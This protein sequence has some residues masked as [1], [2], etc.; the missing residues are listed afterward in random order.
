MQCVADSHEDKDKH[1]L[2]DCCEHIVTT[3]AEGLEHQLHHQAYQRN[4]QPRD[5]TEELVA[6]TTINVDEYN[7]VGQ[8]Q[9]LGQSNHLVPV[10]GVVV[11]APKGPNRM[12]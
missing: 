4:E 2:D 7:K 10:V 9:A 1:E 6:A 8:N 5:E 11:F 3:P 12:R